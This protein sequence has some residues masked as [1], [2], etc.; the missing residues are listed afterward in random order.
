MQTL[1]AMNSRSITQTAQSLLIA[2]TNHVNSFMGPL[3]MTLVKQKAVY[4]G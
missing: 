1:R 3:L 2:I 4:W